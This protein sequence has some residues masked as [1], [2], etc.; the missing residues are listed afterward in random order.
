MS[1]IDEILQK[2]RQRTEH[3]PEAEGSGDKFYSILVGDAIQFHFLELKFSNGVQTCFSYGDL[4][5]FN[6]D[7]EAGCIDLAFGEYLV[8]IKGRGLEPLFIG[9]K[10]KRVEWAKETD[11]EL[12][13]HTGNS[14]FIEAISIT[15]PKEFSE[16]EGG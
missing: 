8:T 1:R 10:Q 14:T 7:P 11:T 2:Q 4:M 3:A 15:P 5:W 12:Q 9:I 6:H 13:D 16:G